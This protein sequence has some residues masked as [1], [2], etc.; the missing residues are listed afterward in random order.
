MTSRVFSYLKKATHVV[1]IASYLFHGVAPAIATKVKFDEVEERQEKVGSIEALHSIILRERQRE[2]TIRQEK[3][4]EEA[5]DGR[6]QYFTPRVTFD[7][8]GYT[9][10]IKALPQKAHDNTG[11]QVELMLSK[12]DGDDVQ[13]LDHRTFTSKTFYREQE[14]GSPFS[15][16]MHRSLG[17]AYS[18][19]GIGIINVC[20]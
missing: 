10:K 4:H 17:F 12:Q 3:K 19:K 9:L 6:H 14:D 2:E 8:A 7:E 18:L 1:V 11:Y 5:Y 16:L 13:T 15:S 20:W